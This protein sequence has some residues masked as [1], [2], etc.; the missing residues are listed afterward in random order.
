MVCNKGGNA[1]MKILYATDGSHY[2]EKAASFLLRLD[3]SASDEIIVLHVISVNPFLDDGETY[4]ARIAQAKK[5]IAPRIVE[6]ACS[7]LRQ[8]KAKITAEIVEGYPDRALIT[9]ARESGAALVVAGAKGASG[10]KAHLVGSV[11]RSLAS[12][13]PRPVLVVRPSRPETTQGIRILFATDGSLQATATAQLLA[14]IPFPRDVDV[15][16]L[17]VVWPS[18][19]DIPQRYAAEIDE[20][21]KSE[22][23]NTRAQEYARSE[24]VIE[25]A[26]R[27]LSPVFTKLDGR[28]RVGNP[29]DEMLDEAVKTHADIV[30][31][32]YH[33]KR[34]PLSM[35]GRVSG[36]I[37]GHSPCSI[38]IGKQES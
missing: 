13:C 18:L 9:R 7:V 35:M 34:A 36:N 28:T 30:A 37:L 15:T 4:Y 10:I 20:R 24:A 8:T 27:I 22:V 19:S 25:E 12:N 16:V 38:I 1:E 29:L 11:T 14:S 33:G 23:A 32:G 21:F 6:S 26:L 17:N 5:D 2:A 3:L 31:V